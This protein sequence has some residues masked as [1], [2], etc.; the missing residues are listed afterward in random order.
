MMV[1][2]L[3]TMQAGYMILTKKPHCQLAGLLRKELFL[4]NDEQGDPISQVR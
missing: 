4:Y 1:V 2:G 3:Q